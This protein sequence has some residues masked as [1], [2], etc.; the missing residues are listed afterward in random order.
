MPEQSATTSHAK[1]STLMA[2]P[3]VSV[4]NGAA[5]VEDLLEAF[6]G[7][8]EV[9]S[10]AAP[11]YD[12]DHGR[13]VFT[14]AGPPG[15]LLDGLV[16]GG[17]LAVEAIDFTVHVGD[18]P[19]VG[20]LDVAP[21]VYLEDSQRGLAWV[22]ALVLADR[23]GQDVGLPVF[24]YGEPG[25]SRTRADLRRG[26]LGALVERIDGGLVSPDFGPRRVEPKAGVTLVTAR[27]PLVAFNI[28]LAPPAGIDDAMAI[29]GQIR[30]G[31][32]RGLPGVRAIGLQLDERGGV[33]Q[34]S[35]NVEDPWSVPLALVVE[36]VEFVAP[37]GATE[38]VGLA[39]AVAFAGFPEGLE[40]RNRATLE[41]A[42]GF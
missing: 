16:A 18:H 19:C 10:I 38:L 27:R 23:L 12:R 4:G 7:P 39:P 2:V 40:C 21:L 13:A 41:D 14:L 24:L 26:G 11:H 31:G 32:E 37:V 3:N 8:G 17:M 20:V 36:A 28:E 1:P 9:R 35:V 30:E 5:L 34:V 29:A 42:L 33:A 6:T 22:E 25:G 15:P